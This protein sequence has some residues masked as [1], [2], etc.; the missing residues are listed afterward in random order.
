MEYGTIKGIEKRTSRLV[1]GT[2]ML[3]EKHREESFTFLDRL[4]QLGCTTFDTAHSYNNG[5]SDSVL[6]RWME[7]RG[8]REDMV[9]IGK[10]AHPDGDRKRV[11]AADIDKDIRESL[12]RLRTDYMDLHLL[13]RDDPTV[14]VGPIVE[15]LNAQREAGRIRAFGGSNWQPAR[16]QEANDYAGAHG[17]VPFV[18]SSPNYSLAVQAEEPWEDCIS[19]G[20]EEN[21]EKRVWYQ[22]SRMPVLA[23]STLGRGFFRGNLTK[24]NFSEMR[25]DL[26]ECCVRAFCTTEN[27]LRL[28][29]VQA[30]AQA[31][32]HSIAQVALAYLFHQPLDL[33]AMVGCTRPESFQ[34]C[35]GA[36]EIKLS[37][38]EIEW[39]DLR[40][41]DAPVG[42]T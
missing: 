40:R 14:P 19:I 11:T 6:G 1:Q 17:L 21:A 13:H 3:W 32:N 10:S 30:L 41:E 25:D 16:I 4:A 27:F 34:E 42:L 28:E 31:R 26:E 20:G 38:S 18:A 2:I 12:E 36:L 7:L 29:R 37:D 15:E 22:E 8:N 35:V 9:I 24:E 5:E 23:W 39:L 33:F